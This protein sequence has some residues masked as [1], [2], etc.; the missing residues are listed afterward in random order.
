MAANDIALTYKLYPELGGP[1]MY[2]QFDKLLKEIEKKRGNVASK[3]L[4]DLTEG[5]QPAEAASGT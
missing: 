3:G 2:R 1:S 4:A 5:Q